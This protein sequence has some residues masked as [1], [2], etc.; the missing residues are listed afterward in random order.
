MISKLVKASDTAPKV[1]SLFEELLQHKN[2]SLVEVILP[3]APSVLIKSV[4][5]SSTLHYFCWRICM[6][7]VLFEE[8][9]IR[10]AYRSS[11]SAE[12]RDRFGANQSASIRIIIDRWLVKQNAKKATVI[13]INYSNQKKKVTESESR[14]A[15]AQDSAADLDRRFVSSYLAPSG[16]FGG[17]VARNAHAVAIDNNR[18]KTMLKRNDVFASAFEHV[19]M[20]ANCLEISKVRSK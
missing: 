11:D 4:C 16:P 13:S 7:T 15:S 5:L 19:L 14:I 12:H 18:T 6:N 17:I 20:V 2:F 8:F 9:S 1:T 3:T 10:Y